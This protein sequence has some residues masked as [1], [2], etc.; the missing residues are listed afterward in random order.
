VLG[1]IILAQR[2]AR[3]NV[4][5]ALVWIGAI[6]GFAYSMHLTYIEAYEIKSFCPYCVKSAW[7]MTGVFAA[8]LA[9]VIA[10]ESKD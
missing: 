10:F 2:P 6:I 7:A 4:F 5:V 3:P 1:L 9:Q 8:V